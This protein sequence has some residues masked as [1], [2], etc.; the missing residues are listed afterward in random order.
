[1]SIREIAETIETIAG[2]PFSYAIGS[3]KDRL[4]YHSSEGG[5]L[6]LWS[7]DVDSRSRFRITPGPVEYMAEPRHDSNI[8]YYAKDAAKGAELHK[9]YAADAIEGN[10]TLAVDLTPMRVEGLASYGRLVAFTAATKEEMALY[11]SKSGHLEKRRVVPSSAILSDANERYLIGTGNLAKN[12]RSFE[13]FIFDLSTGNYGEYTP[14]SDSVNKSPKLN[15]DKILFESNYTGKNQLHM[16]DLASAKL[17]NIPFASKDYQLYD[18]IEH[19]NFGWI[20][21]DKVWFVGKRNGEAKAFIDG[22]EAKTPPGFL[23]GMT[24]WKG[25]AY[26]LHCSVVQP[27]RL[28][29]GDGKNKVIVEP[30]VPQGIIEKVGKGRLVSFRSF[31]GRNIAALVVDH[32]SP[33]PTVVLVHGGPWSEYPNTWGPIICSVAASGYNV[34]APNFRGSTG[35]GEEF[36]NLDIGDPGGGDFQDVVYATRWAKQNN[37]ATE[38]AIMG[39]S[40]GGYMTLLALGKEPELWSCG[41]AGAPVTDWNEMHKLSDALYRDFIEELFDKKEELFSDRSPITY[42]KNVKKPICIIASQ[43]DT[44]TPIKPVLRYALELANNSGPFELHSIPDMGHS[45]GSTQDLVD[46]LLPGIAFL[47]KRFPV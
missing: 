46:I 16:Y 45:T 2:I 26:V 34:I 1:M 14:K 11:T 4:V 27:M 30:P 41:V 38:A 44:R 40:Y 31:D 42:V 23:W 32:G 13:I 36:R 28:L 25:K 21:N 18:P 15:G 20:D 35:Y 3:T 19:P 8:V 12:P 37:L 9:I 29:E 39:Y 47:R 6:T 33:R 5:T 17:S 24:V 7:V 22:K 43:N 10:E